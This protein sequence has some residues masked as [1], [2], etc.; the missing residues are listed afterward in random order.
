MTAS[1]QQPAA[2]ALG[3]WWRVLTEPS[4]GRLPSSVRTYLGDALDRL[5]IRECLYSRT[6]TALNSGGISVPCRR[7]LI[8]DKLGNVSLPVWRQAFL[9]FSVPAHSQDC[10][11]GQLDTK[12]KHP[13]I[14][15]CQE[16][17]MQTLK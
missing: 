6:M 4:A 2:L 7:D 13:Q 11:E 10:S 12:R 14:R 17:M 3:S 16:T 1:P 5:I 8:L 9:V 15:L